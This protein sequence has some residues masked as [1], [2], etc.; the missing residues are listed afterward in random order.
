MKAA[1]LIEQKKPLTLADIEL[2]AE[3]QYGQVL[4][5]IHY[6]GICGSQIGEIDGVK[7][8]DRFLP[9]LLGHEAG[10]VVEKCGPGVTK[11]T[12]EDHV[13]L[14]WR[15]GEGIEASPATYQWEDKVVNSGWVTTFSEYSVVSEN[16]VTRIPKDLD[17]EMAALY[18]CAIPT[19]FG[20][21][22]NN[23]KLQIGESIVIFGVGGIGMATVL[24]GKMT[25]AYPIIAIDIS[26]SKLKIAKKYG[27]THTINSKTQ[28]AGQAI[29][30]ILPE[31]ADVVVETVGVRAIRELAYEMTS[32]QGRTILVGVPK[33]PGEKMSID[34]LQLHFTKS[35]TG[36]HGGDIN[37][38]YHLPRFIRLQQNG[39][40]DPREMITHSFPLVKINEALDLIRQGE[41]IRCS[42]KMEHSK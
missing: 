30:E 2:P 18:G 23:A 7:G 36:C 29:A 34:S 20:A 21:V 6:S 22:F 31:G 38:S 12:A 27:A 40:F 24:A 37:P 1:I 16:R 41:V 33:F 39:I 28:E 17:L 35:I 14:H 42:I 25:S 5:K 19:A 4:I 9:H 10:G 11:V 15:K 3:L 26:K 32:K 13:V 8:P